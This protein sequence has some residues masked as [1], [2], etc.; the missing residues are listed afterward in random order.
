M[1]DPAI[2]RW[3]VV[4][5]LAEKYGAWSPYNYVYNNPLKFVDPTGMGPD[6]D[7]YFNKQG[8]IVLHVS[9]KEPD[10]FF[11]QKTNDDLCAPNCE[12]TQETSLF[13]QITMDSD[14]GLIARTTYAEQSG[15]DV[16]TMD[17]TAE[18]IINRTELPNN[19][20]AKV[21]TVSEAINSSYD[22]S[23][24]K[25]NPKRSPDAFERF[26]FPVSSANSN[27]L[28]KKSF[29]QS[30]G[31]AIRAVNKDVNQSTNTGTGIIFYHAT[32][33][34]YRDNNSLLQKI[35]LSKLN[36]SGIKGAWK[37]KN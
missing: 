30:I 17:L 23:K 1:F 37:Y 20:D 12:V 24:A 29:I 11:V 16:A 10:R 3:G 25:D 19:K 34:T 13:S 35:D 33:A 9:N 15:Q 36:P 2:G 18:S 28:E 5:P 6:D 27:P 4:D 22:V 32:N 21:N 26:N 7:Y 8:Q 14:I 31:A